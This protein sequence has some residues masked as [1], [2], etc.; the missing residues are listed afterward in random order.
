MSKENIF[1]NMTFVEIKDF[2]DD[3]IKTTVFETGCRENDLIL[4]I[5][6]NIKSY[7]PVDD[8]FFRSGKLLKKGSVNFTRHPM[9]IC[10]RPVLYIKQLKDNSIVCVNIKN[11]KNYL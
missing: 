1:K 3:I 10:D 7:L 2:F 5:S 11:I 6:E 8:D 9:L 4:L